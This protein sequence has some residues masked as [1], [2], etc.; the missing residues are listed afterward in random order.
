MIKKLSIFIG[1]TIISMPVLS[2]FA[3]QQNTALIDLKTNPSIVK[4]N[5]FY[6]KEVIDSRKN[7]SA[8]GK[9]QPY[10]GGTTTLPYNTNLKGGSAALSAFVANSVY[11]DKEQRSIILTINE[12]SVNEEPLTIGAV[13]GNIK[14]SL[15]FALQGTYSDIDLTSYTSSTTFQR[16]AGSPQQIEPILSKT[17]TNGLIFFDNWMNN[18]AGD[19]IKLAT[20]VKLSFANYQDK[21]EGDTIYYRP[22]RPLTWD[23]FT[24]QPSKSLKHAAEVFSY[25]GYDQDIDLKNGVVYV[26]ISLKPWVAKSASWVKPGQQNN[27]ALNHEQRHF[28]IT[29]LVAE[30]FKK[31]LSDLKLAPDTFEG[32][33]NMAYLDALRELNTLQKQYDTETV[34]ARD[35]GEQQRWNDR[36]DKEL[37]SAGIKS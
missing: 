12:L 21:T 35:S 31:R 27:Y 11:A 6:I 7:K 2:C 20:A 10:K 9:M 16:P 5:Q 25:I 33:I 22:D 15:S 3:Q 13:K 26:K 29:R 18:N 1:F 17:I 37:I 30:H 4:P 28:D 24:G 32:E 8:L 36:I 23:D 14:I 19:N 34:H